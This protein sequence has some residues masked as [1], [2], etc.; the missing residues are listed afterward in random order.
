LIKPDIEPE[1]S[2]EGFIVQ[3]GEAKEK[4]TNGT[5][6]LVGDGEK[7]TKTGIKIDDRVLFEK[8]GGTYYISDEGEEFLII[9]SD[10]ILA[11]LK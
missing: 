3:I 4:K 9:D 11:I 1:K 7:I 2:K 8:W 6:I 10:K 5:V